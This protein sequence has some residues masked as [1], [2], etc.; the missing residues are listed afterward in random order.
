MEN[1]IFNNEETFNVLERINE[2]METL[3]PILKELVDNMKLLDF[4]K[5]TMTHGKTE[6]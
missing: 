1:F 6:N 5:I 4:L 3:Q 2:D